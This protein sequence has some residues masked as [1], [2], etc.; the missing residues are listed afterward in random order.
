L[1]TN[2]YSNSATHSQ[3]ITYRLLRLAKK[4]EVKYLVCATPDLVIP[5]SLQSRVT[6]K[7][8]VA[9][10]RKRTIPTERPSPVGEVSANFCG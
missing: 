1:K 3:G 7:N 5:L 10:V 2:T 6:P 4:N 9:L 8:S